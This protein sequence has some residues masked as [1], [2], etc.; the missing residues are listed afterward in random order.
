MEKVNTHEE[1]VKAPVKE[2]KLNPEHTASNAEKVKVALTKLASDVV[3]AVEK[4][5]A[6][7]PVEEVVDPTLFKEDSWM[8]HK[9]FEPKLFAKGEKIPED[10][11]HL[12][13]WGWLRDPK[14]GFNWRK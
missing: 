9:D 4:P 10:W 3:K 8:F 14:N 13:K 5:K 1:L 11:S 2:V 12:N 6:P 7:A